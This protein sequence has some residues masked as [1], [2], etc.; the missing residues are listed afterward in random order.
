MIKRSRRHGTMELRSYAPGDGGISFRW[1][2]QSN[3][4]G[5]ALDEPVTESDVSEWLEQESQEKW[6][7]WDIVVFRH[8]VR[9]RYWKVRLGQLVCRPF[10][11]SNKL[12]MGD[13]VYE[14][15][16]D[17][18]KGVTESLVRID[19][20][21]SNTDFYSLGG[22]RKVKI[23]NM[24]IILGLLFFLNHEEDFERSGYEIRKK[25]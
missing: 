3:S 12:V 2:S 20:R 18:D 7:G 19:Y 4:L 24:T 13:E 1:V 23:E 10:H 16:H 5:E 21:S 6:K 25:K 15:H 8:L 22:G 11:T 17:N 14:Y 9:D